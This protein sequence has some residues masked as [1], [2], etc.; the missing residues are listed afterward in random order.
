[1]LALAALTGCIG[2]FEPAKPD[3][4][5]SN[6]CASDFVADGSSPTTLL[7][8]LTSAM[9]LRARGRCGY[10]AVF[11]DSVT[12][13]LP[14]EATFPGE[15]VAERERLHLPVPTWRRTHELAFYDDFV[16]ITSGAIDLK[17]T[18]YQESGSDSRDEATGDSTLH[19][20]Y[21]VT[22]SGGAQTLAAG[23]AHLRFRHLLSGH[24]VLT[25]WD[26]E[27]DPLQPGTDSERL[28]LTISQ[29]RLEAYDAVF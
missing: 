25:L 6:N 27:I 1:M 12:D 7:K 11:A 19:R 10:I 15:I 22:T 23:V 17:W 24:W 3:P 28:D 26:D 13:R 21:V 14:Y 2:L 20:R 9:K 4:P 29:R 16:E 18:V 5:L 8:T